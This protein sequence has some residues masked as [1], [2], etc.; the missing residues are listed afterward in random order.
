MKDRHFLNRISI[1]W[2]IFICL[3]LFAGI[4]LAFLWVFQVALLDT[5]YEH[6]KQSEITFCAQEIKKKL[7][8]DN[9]CEEDFRATLEKLSQEKSMC[10]LITDE[11]GYVLESHET[12]PNCFIH[13]LD[14]VQRMQMYLLTVK[15][16][17]SYL[18]RSWTLDWKNNHALRGI[19]DQPET[20][21][22]TN[23]F[24]NADGQVRFV[25]LNTSLTP[26]NA[27][28]QTLLVQLVWIT[29]LMILLAILIAIFLS[30]KISRPI[31]GINQ[32]AKALGQIN[33]VACFD[34]SGYL[35]ISEL[36]RTL[37]YAARELSKAERL[38]RELIA[39]ISHDL[40]TPLTMIT[41][42]SE[43]MRDI[44][45]ENTPENIQVVID[46]ARWLTTLVND[47]LD[48]SKLQS[49]AQAVHRMPFNLTESIRD[50]L[51]RYV[52]LAD[53]NISL[54]AEQEVWVYADEV[55]LS[56]VL[57]NL[58][59]NAINYT[60]ADK[61][62]MITQTVLPG[63]PGRVRVAVTDT[64]E[65]VAPDQL[66][67]IWN[68]YYKVDKAH[69]R[70]QVGTGLGLSIVKTVLDLHGGASY[71]VDSTVGHGSTFW[72]ELP[73]YPHNLLH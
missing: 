6:I 58:V 35:E 62:V 57:Y 69:K 59:N 32:S 31:I 11:M 66:A 67:D 28:G 24:T 29:V 30:R 63:E 3:M 45:G 70:A 65:G 23:V 44:P 10:I 21:I 60:G 39:N 9:L 51:Q 55:R 47:L 5:F 68:R 27:T 54:E 19:A 61:R 56:Q 22:Y 14:A 38:Q 25:M 18:E 40:R 43:V 12:A 15:H 34:E 7:Q 42:Y 73:I 64:G 49:G 2:N 16:G 20:I 37:N 71:G 48:I 52:K 53:Y 26:V 46:E 13:R 4:I 41:G 72:F 50:I 36:A 17:G 33:E 1:K 8:Q